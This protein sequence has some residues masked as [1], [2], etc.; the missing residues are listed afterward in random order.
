MAAYI[1][2]GEGHTPHPLTIDAA[3]QILQLV[4]RAARFKRS[5]S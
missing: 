4:K 5:E 2:H 3:Q 1:P